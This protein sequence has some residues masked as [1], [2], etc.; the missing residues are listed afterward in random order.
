MTL[1]NELYR[2]YQTNE[3][4]IFKGKK[5]IATTPAQLEERDPGRTAYVTRADDNDPSRANLLN[6]TL[7]DGKK[8]VI[9]NSANG[10]AAQ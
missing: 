7:S 1:A 9:G 8:A 5:V 10:S 3:L 4:T 6:V 2:N